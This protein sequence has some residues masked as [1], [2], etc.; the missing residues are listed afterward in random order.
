MSSPSWWTGRGSRA[1]RMA[2]LGYCVPSA[3]QLEERDASAA[4]RR[5]PDL[6]EPGELGLRQQRPRFS[7]GVERRK[8]LDDG[9]R[10][11]RTIDSRPWLH[12]STKELST[13]LTKLLL[14]MLRGGDPS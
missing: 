7:E 13:K 4:E 10:M 8:Q 5:A 2:A 11:A 14:S 6:R 3:V 1:E 9:Y 12:G